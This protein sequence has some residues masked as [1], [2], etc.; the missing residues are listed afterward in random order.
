M[1]Q[2]LPWIEAYRPASVSEVVG[3]EES[4]AYLHKLSLTRNVPHLL[5]AGPPGTGKTT[6]AHALA[7]T[8]WQH[9]YTQGVLTLNGSDDRGLDVVRGRIV[10][11]ATHLATPPPGWLADVPPL[12]P[13]THF[14]LQVLRPKFTSW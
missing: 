5:L 3:N 1:H 2:A 9:K 6:C 7:A 10:T 13:S 11:F 4:V 12:S 8:L 14:S